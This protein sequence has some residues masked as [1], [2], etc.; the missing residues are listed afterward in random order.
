MLN[1]NTYS[2]TESWHVDSAQISMHDA[3][4]S[5]V[6]AC[7]S[8]QEIYP[9]CLQVLSRTSPWPNEDYILFKKL[10]TR[11]RPRF[12]GALKEIPSSLKDSFYAVR[13]LLLVFKSYCVLA[14][15]CRNGSK[16]MD[17]VADDM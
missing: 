13:N 14:L 8:D 7:A 1:K 9:S 5:V 3:P 4:H 10:V 16:R 11:L 15:T 2:I 17:P 12:E 6:V